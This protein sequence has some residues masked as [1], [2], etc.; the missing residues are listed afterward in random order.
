MAC[1]SISTSYRKGTCDNIAAGVGAFYI[2]NHSG[3]TTTW[4]YGPSTGNAYVTGATN[5]PSF[6]LCEQRVQTAEFKEETVVND[7][8]GSYNIRQTIKVVLLGQNNKNRQFANKLLAGSYEVIVKNS[9]GNYVLLGIDNGLERGGDS[10]AN[11]GI[12]AGD[13]NTIEITLTGL[14]TEFA[15]VIDITSTAYTNTL[16]VTS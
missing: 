1:G 3:E 14:A 10:N 12:S 5:N 11:P 6:F 4:A 16:L 15:P 9:D 8:Y 7:Q 13:K 2:G